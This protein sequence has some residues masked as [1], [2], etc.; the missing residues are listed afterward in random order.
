MNEQIVELDSGIELAYESFGDPEDPLMLLVMGLGVQMLGWDTRFCRELVKRGF[1]V[2]RFDNRDVGHSTKLEEAG[3]P[4]LMGALT[5]DL[6]SA[7][8]TLEDMADDTA[9]LIE[10]LGGGPAHV[11][12]ASLG[13]MIG[14]TLAARRPDLVA[15]LT[16]IMSSTGNSAVGQPLDTVLPV[17]LTPAP[18]HREAFVEMSV[19]TFKAIGSPGFP[20]NEDRVRAL[21]GAS[22]DRCY[23]PA[24]VGRQLMAAVASGDRTEVLRTI[25]APTLVI[26]GEDDPLIQHSGGEATA[27]AIPDAELISIP[28]MGHDL[29]E[30][31]WPRFVDAIVGNTERARERV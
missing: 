8:Y 17:L 1:H 18:P 31:L 30:Q 9:G 24:G 11:V 28:G 6:S 5:G 4:N 12:G 14:Q 20:G 13:G 16:S 25:R 21:A 7:A 27:E 19:E 29:P 2:V 23:H 3:L 22:F 26:H 15:S 10:H